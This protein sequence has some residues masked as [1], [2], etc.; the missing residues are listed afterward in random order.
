MKIR[1]I[2]G[3]VVSVGFFLSTIYMSYHLVKNGDA[4]WWFA[5]IMEFVFAGLCYGLFRACTMKT[6]QEEYNE[7]FPNTDT[8]E[9]QS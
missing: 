3:L 7:R 6:F 2:I 8:Q 9:S 5:V 4:I 1:T